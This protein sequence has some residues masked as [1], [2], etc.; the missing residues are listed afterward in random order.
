MAYKVFISTTTDA[1]S[2]RYAQAVKTALWRLNDFPVAPVSM[3]DFAGESDPLALAR[4]VID[5]AQIFIGVYGD[6]YGDIPAGET[7]SLLELEYNYARERGLRTLVFLPQDS[8]VSNDRLQAFKQRLKESQVVHSFTSLDDLQAKVVVAVSNVKKAMRSTPTPSMPASGLLERN[9]TEVADTTSLETLVLQALN[10]ADDEIEAIIRRALTL[11]DAQRAITD[12]P[13]TDADHEM[14]VRPIF[15]APLMGSQ[16][17]AD[18]FMIMPFRQQYNAVYE[19]IIKPVV[20]DLNLTIKRGDDFSSQQGA[21]MQ[22]VWSAIYACKLVIVETTE[23][24]PNVFY[25]LGIAHTLG[26][27][28]ILITQAESASDF[29]F[30]IRHLRFLRYQNTIVG[31]ETLEQE[32][33]KQIIWLMNDLKDDEG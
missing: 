16:F 21:I 7:D 3:Q 30:D 2:L 28:A 24:N 15:G 27:P 23:D 25:E 13:L 5:D 9:V 20:A 26:K 31:G 11:H 22:E 4:R 6:N 12:E 18:I 14:Q 19:N 29:P 1:Q 8:D 17:Q 33:R 10:I 32:L